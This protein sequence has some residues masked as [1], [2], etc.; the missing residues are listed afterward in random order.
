MKKMDILERELVLGLVEYSTEQYNEDITL[1]DL[2]ELINDIKGTS[3][4][5]EDFY[6]EFLGIEFRII[7]KDFIDDI[8]GESLEQMCEECYLYDLP[9]IAQRYFDMKAFIRDCKFD[10]MGHHFNG[11]DGSEFE[12]GTFHYF[13]TN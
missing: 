5:R 9:E 3:E 2:K 1:E 4:G 13:R 11:Y 7:D 12:T 10:G 6:V 8:W